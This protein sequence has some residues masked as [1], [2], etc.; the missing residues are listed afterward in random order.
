MGQKIL[1]S[2]EELAEI[3]SVLATA[4]LV[5]TERAKQYGSPHKATSHIAKMWTALLSPKLK[6][7]EEITHSDVNMLMIC[8]KL[9]RTSN[10]NM[11]KDSWIDIAG[12]CGV[13]WS[14]LVGEQFDGEKPCS[15]KP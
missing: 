9:V 3:H 14:A 2:K 6:D 12:Y 10:D 11:H 13:A 15:K 8:L 1:D 4:T 5:T 7:G